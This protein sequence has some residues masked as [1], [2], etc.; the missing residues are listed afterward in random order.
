MVSTWSRFFPSRF[1]VDESLVSFN[2]VESGLFLPTASLSLDDRFVWAKSSA[3]GRVYGDGPSMI[4]HVSALAFPSRD[5]GMALLDDVRAS[6]RAMGYESWQFGGDWRHF[7]PG[8]PIECTELA[9]VLSAAGMMRQGA[10]VFDV[11]RDLRGYTPPVPPSSDVRVCA[12]ADSD[13]LSAFLSREFPGR[14][15]SDV[16]EKFGEDPSRI[17][18]LVLAGAIEGFA[19]TQME[20]DAHRRA[21]AVWSASLGP[22]WA[23]L[24]PIGVSKSLRGLGHGHALLAYALCSLR[25]QG[26]RQT[27]IDWTVLTDFYGLHGF[28]VS[29]EYVT[30]AGQV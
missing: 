24:G 7:F 12:A 11:E 23:A 17:Y 20:W 22:G 29:R 2:M 10:S 6:L 8:C 16:M 19:M 9:S 1:S 25:D 26:A 28:E 5:A 30:Y 27:I 21:G 15:H 13:A 4:A 3:V 14:W 18:V